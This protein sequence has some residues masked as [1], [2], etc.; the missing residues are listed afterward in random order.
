MA[1]GRRAEIGGDYAGHWIE[2]DPALPLAAWEA[3]LDDD[4]EALER[5]FRAAVRRWSLDAPVPAVRPEVLDDLVPWDWWRLLPHLFARAH[6]LSDEEDIDLLRRASVGE[7]VVR[8]P[9]LDKY[10]RCKELGI[11]FATSYEALPAGEILRLR[12][13]LAKEAEY[14]ESMKME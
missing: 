3:L 8:I 6:Q 2:F 9:E 1:V 12:Q 7:G 4:H 11:P 5:F 10:R 14:R 13:A